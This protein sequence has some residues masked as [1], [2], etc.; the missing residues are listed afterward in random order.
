[1][2]LWL[3]ASGEGLDSLKWAIYFNQPLGNT[4]HFV[5]SSID[6]G[7]IIFQEKIDLFKEIAWMN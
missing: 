5:D 1:M 6:D 2:P 3:D 4:L 7:E